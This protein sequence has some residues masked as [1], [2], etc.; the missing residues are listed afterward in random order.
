M[1]KTEGLKA[2]NLESLNQFIKHSGTSFFVSG[3]LHIINYVS[4]LKH[5]RTFQN[6]SRPSLVVSFLD[7]ILIILV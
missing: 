4:L 7:K 3:E 2:K 5:L 6:V 1:G